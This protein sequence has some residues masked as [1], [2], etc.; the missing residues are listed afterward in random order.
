[1]IKLIL[2]YILFCL[3]IKKFKIKKLDKFVITNYFMKKGNKFDYIIGAT[4]S[5]KSTLSAYY[6]KKALKKGQSVYSFTPIFGAYKINREDIGVYD[7]SNSLLII[8]EAGIEFDNRKFKSNFTNEQLDFFKKHRHYNVDIV[9][10]S[11]SLDTDK[12]LR[13]L[14]KQIFLVKRS[15]FPTHFYTKKINKKV[16]INELTK[17]LTDEFYFVPFSRKYFLASKYWKYFES[18]QP[19]CLKQKMFELYKIKKDY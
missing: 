15:L 19:K 17:E 8:D 3:I 12:K 11:Q 2:I 1:M 6:T 14:S 7:I 4:G 18:L 9:I 13:D 5:G 16:G 10:I